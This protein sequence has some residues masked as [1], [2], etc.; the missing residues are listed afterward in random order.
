VHAADSALYLCLAEA[1]EGEAV[2][3]LVIATAG[4]A[5]LAGNTTLLPEATPCLAS[6]GEATQ[7]TVLVHR[8]ADPVDAG[9]LHR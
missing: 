3:A 5:G 7:L 1:A 2:A 9:V 4:G 6:S 8:V